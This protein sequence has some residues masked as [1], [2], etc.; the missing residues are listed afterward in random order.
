MNDWGWTAWW[1]KARLQPELSHQLIHKIIDSGGS[2]KDEEFDQ[3]VVEKLLSVGEWMG[4][5]V[6]SVVSPHHT[7]CYT[8]PFRVM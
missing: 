3:F 4:A 1:R 2:E 6:T 7:T 8:R 5:A